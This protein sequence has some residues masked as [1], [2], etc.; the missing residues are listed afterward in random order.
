MNLQTKHDLNWIIYMNQI[1]NNMNTL[2]KVEL[3]ILEDAI[4]D[5]YYSRDKN[6]KHLELQTKIT[7]MIKNAK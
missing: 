7:N 3:Y 4:M 5:Y 2:T 1:T 6:P